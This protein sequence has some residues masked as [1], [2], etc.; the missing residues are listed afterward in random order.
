MNTLMQIE[1]FILL[2]YFPLLI[3]CQCGVNW[4]G[5]NCTEPNLCHGKTEFCPDD[6]HCQISGENQECT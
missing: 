5:I 4:F 1:L 3:R 2:L 6:F